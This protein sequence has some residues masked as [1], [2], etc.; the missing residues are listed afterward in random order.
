MGVLSLLLGSCLS[1]SQDAQDNK[2]VHLPVRCQAQVQ[3]LALQ[4]AVH[5][6]QHL[7]EGNHG[8]AGGRAGG[9]LSK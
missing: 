4:Q 1:V 7:Q 8:R 9:R 6:R 5:E 2:Q 3:V